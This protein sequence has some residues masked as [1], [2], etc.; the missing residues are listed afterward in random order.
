MPGGTPALLSQ[1]TTLIP[2]IALV[3]GIG[4]GVLIIFAEQSYPEVVLAGVLGLGGC[5]AGLHNLIDQLAGSGRAFRPGPVARTSGGAELVGKAAAPSPEA[6]R[7][8][9]ARAGGGRVEN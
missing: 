8:I 5:A 4:I 9:I 7:D 1:R 2:F 3:S 6:V